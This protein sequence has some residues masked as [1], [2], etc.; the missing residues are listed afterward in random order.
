MFK[1]GRPGLETT[2]GNWKTCLVRVVSPQTG[3]QNSGSSDLFLAPPG[4]GSSSTLMKATG[5]Y[6]PALFIAA[7]AKTQVDYLRSFLG[8]GFAVLMA[9]GLYIMTDVWFLQGLKAILL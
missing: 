5:N 7:A 9:L 4:S 6:L 8:V 2:S 3:F 1:N